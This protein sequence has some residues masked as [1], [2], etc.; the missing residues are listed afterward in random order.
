MRKPVLL[1]KAALLSPIEQSLKRIE[2]IRKHK[3]ETQEP[4]ILEGLFVLAISSFET[5]LTDTIRILLSHFPEKLDA[6]IEKV[7]KEDLIDGTLLEK[8]INQK[9]NSISYKNLEEIL[10]YLARITGISLDTI[11]PETKNQLVEIKASRNLLVHNNLKVN[12]I[13]LETAGPDKREKQ[14]GKQLEIDQK[15]LFRSITILNDFLLILEK[16]LK[17][18]YNKYTYLNAIKN[19]WE[20]IF[21]NLDIEKEFIL[22]EKNDIVHNYNE[23]ESRRDSFSTSEEMKFSLWLSHFHSKPIKLDHNFYRF[24]NEN[25]AKMTY[26]ISVIDFIKA[27]S[28]KA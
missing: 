5:C 7:N 28:P 23:K 27:R 2:R 14:T 9:V 21:P 26:L 18:K 8:T 15:Y 25:R 20:Y 22:D 3:T 24:D 13:Y 17:E 19:L 1:T 12:S 10:K 4:I 16:E 11:Q 6:I